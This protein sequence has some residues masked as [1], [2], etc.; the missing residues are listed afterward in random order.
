MMS[1]DSGYGQSSLTKVCSSCGATLSE[2]QASCPRC[3][4]PTNAPKSNN[5]V[6]CGA[7]L[8]DGQAFCQKCGQKVGLGIDQSAIPA[9]S[10]LT[11]SVKANNA[12]SR[13]DALVVVGV[14]VAI[15][16][17]ILGF[18]G[19]LLSKEDRFAIEAAK[20]LQD[21]LLAPNS[22][23]LM[24]VYVD[25][26]KY[27]HSG[28]ERWI[29]ARVFMYFASTNKG[30]G[31]TDSNCCVLL[32]SDGNNSVAFEH[33]DIEIKYA[34]SIKSAT[35]RLENAMVPDS[36]IYTSWTKVDAQK[37]EKRILSK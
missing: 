23:H 16:I 30:G 1:L 32:M 2:G 7:E 20:E 15:L 35:Y 11:S 27:D 26:A 18:G 3:G 13:K 17:G 14:I 29:R 5:C 8:R 6:R 31:I 25:V 4:T 22:I 28:E 37:I 19:F 33:S 10:Q 24:R 21:R 12:K 9:A 34:D 36:S